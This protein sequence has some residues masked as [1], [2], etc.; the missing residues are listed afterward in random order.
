MPSATTF[1]VSSGSERVI[2]VRRGASSGGSASIHSPTSSSSRSTESWSDL[3]AED[4]DD[5]IE[6]S[7]SASRTLRPTSRRHT[8]EVR[9]APTRRHSS[10]RVVQEREEESPPPRVR[11]R[12]THTTSRHR[13]AE[14]RRTPSDESGSVASYDDYP[15][16]HPGAPQPPRAGYPPQSGYRH[17]PAPS[18]G[19]YPPGMT[20]AAPYI[21][22]YTAQQQQQ[23][24]VPMPHQDAFGYQPNPFS[25]Q[26]QPNN[27]F[28]PMSAVSGTSYFGMDPHAAP[29]LAAHPQHPQRPGVQRPQSFVAPSHYGSDL[30]MSPYAYSAHPG[31]G[32]PAHPAMSPYGYPP[33]MPPPWGYAQPPVPSQSTTPAPPAAPAT[34]APDPEKE[35]IQKELEAKQEKIQKEFDAKIEAMKAELEKSQAKMQEK[36]STENAARETAKAQETAKAAAEVDNLRVMIKKYEE[37]QA[38]AEAAARAK[39]AEEEA[40]KKKKA[41]IAEAIKKAKEDVEK[42]AAEATAK[43]KEEHAK[44][45][46]ELKAAQ[47]EA[48]KKQKELEDEAAKNKPLP[49]TLKAPI[50]FKDAVGRKF[51]FPWHLCKT[52]K[53]MENLI[54]QAFAHV[55]GIGEHVHQGHYD[56]TGPDGEIILP[57]VWDTMIQPD[58]EINMHMWPMPEPKEEKKPKEQVIDVGAGFNNDPLAGFF[59]GLGIVDTQQMPAKKPKKDKDKDK[60]KKGK[61]NSPEIV[62]VMPSNAAM[63]TA[64]MPPPPNFPPGMWNDPMGGFPM[65]GG[66]GPPLE[67]ERRPKAKSKGSKELTGLAAWIAGGQKKRR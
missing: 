16:G 59:D 50:K 62:N 14:S 31:S 33:H 36:E 34:P 38:A 55:D 67:K 30:A 64:P 41:E 7:D 12:A 56:L 21:D 27:P 49:D 22:P 54:K 24:L 28:S 43:T 65:M 9:P 46:A 63:G 1:T 45:L 6:P 32:H 44:A 18:Q 51:S 5:L 35:K 10:R 52:W 26:H 11:R 19:G 60:K 53:G 2:R 39:K 4:Q 42:K 23:A 58:W 37:A 57:Q 3:G 25:P 15:Y 8:T 66:M 40:D 29:Q 47:E 20:S 61:P 48:V 17:V 13:R